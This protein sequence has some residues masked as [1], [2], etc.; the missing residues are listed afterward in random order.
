M[1]N[2]NSNNNVIDFCKVLSNADESEGLR[3]KVKIPGADNG[4]TNV[5]DLPYAFPLLPKMLHAYPKKD[6]TVLVFLTGTGETKGQRF[7][8]GPI[9]SQPQNMYIDKDTL[10]SKSLLLD[11]KQ[12]KPLPAPSLNPDNEGTLPDY[13]DIA[14]EGRCNSDVIL[15]DN[16]VRV[17]CG[18]KKNPQ[19][20]ENVRLNYN[21]KDLGY[22]QLKYDNQ[23]RDDKGREFA[24][25]A[26]VVADRINLLSHDSPYGIKLGDKEKLITDDAM[27]EIFEKAHQLPYGDILVDFLKMFLTIFLTHT[28]PFPMKPTIVAPEQQEDLKNKLATMLSESIRIN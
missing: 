20:D 8:I 26:N 19:G 3:I 16:E 4:I 23:L 10:S 5:K 15:K 2:D 24:S 17:R 11:N 6:E 25:V 13:D 22:I 9:I 21:D 12:Q 18:Y 7:Y 1:A 27:R 14:L 28:H